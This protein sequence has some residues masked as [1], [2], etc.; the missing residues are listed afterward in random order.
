MNWLIVILVFFLMAGLLYVLGVW[1]RKIEEETGRKTVAELR[2][3]KEYGTDKPL[4]QYP[5]IDAASCIGCGTCVAAC[6]EDGVL[7]LVDGIARVI[8]GARCVGHGVCAEVCPVGAIVVGLGDVSSR[9]DIP[10]LDRS[11]ETSAPGIFIAGELGGLGLIRIAIQQ[12]TRAIDAIAAELHD[13]GPAPQGV[14]DILIVG[15]GPAGIAA[16][17]RC[18]ERK[19]AYV[20]I[21]QEDLGGTVRKYPRRKLVLTGPVDLPLHGRIKKS[22]FLKE[23]LIEFWESVFQEHQLLVRSRVKLLGLQGRR[24]DFLAQT[25][26]G[27]LRARRVLLA[28]GRRGTPRKLG[29]PG[30][31]LEKVL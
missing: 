16:T 31:D 8:H 18:V 11:L 21:D 15:A 4:T 5:R 13:E 24:G 30:E 25:S 9:S 7:G 22:E 29:V 14:A 27:P 17:L 28:L 1:Q 12:G 2:E 20:T 19:L 10:V 3:A 26:T 6:P 23:E